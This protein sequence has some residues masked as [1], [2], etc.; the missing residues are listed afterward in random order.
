M[1]LNLCIC[2]KYSAQILCFYYP[3]I[4][5]IMANA[6][7]FGIPFRNGARVR[8]ESETTYDPAAPRSGP[9][10]TE[11]SPPDVRSLKLLDGVGAR[12]NTDIRFGRMKIFRT[13]HSYGSTNF[14][15]SA[16][17]SRFIHY[18]MRSPEYLDL[19][20][21]RSLQGLV[22]VG[23]TSNGNDLTMVQG[24]YRCDSTPYWA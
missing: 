20:L 5:P 16:E 12:K 22:A 17:R 7:P 11:R 9:A 24:L 6:T 8:S 15:A 3:R 14:G 2:L 19:R 18:S 4:P 13:G 10:T 23:S 21:Q 1:F